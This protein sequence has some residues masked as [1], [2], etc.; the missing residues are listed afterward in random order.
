VSDY[1]LRLGANRSARSVLSRLRLPIPL[2][3]RLT[4]SDDPACADRAARVD[5]PGGQLHDH[6]ALTVARAGMRVFVRGSDN[7]VAPY[8]SGAA[9]Y[10]L[11]ATRL[12]SEATAHDGVQALIFD[13]SGLR[14][15]DDLHALYD[16]L[17]PTVRQ[18]K[19]CGR[20]I[21]FG[22]PLDEA[23]TAQ[24]AATQAAL[25]G[26]VRS[27]GKELGRRGTTANLI[28]VAT[29]AEP[30]LEPALRWLL[31]PRSAF[32]SGQTLDITGAAVGSV[33]ASSPRPLA[34]RR[35]LVTGAARGIGE[36]TATALA[37]AGAHVLCLDRP[38]TDG[39]LARLAER[40]GGTAVAL[41]ITDS[42]APEQLVEYVQG[43]LHG[44]VHNAGI[45]RDR[46]LA[47][48]SRDS[49]SATLSVN[50]LAITLLHD[51][52]D[53][54]LVD[55]ARV[56]MLSS[57]AGIAGNVGQS[58][59]AASK[60]GVIGLVKHLAPRLAARGITVNAVAPGFIETQ[61]TAAIPMATREAGRRLSS[62]AQGGLPI[63]VAELVTFL[64]EPGSIGL[65]GTTVRVCGQ[66][67][68]GA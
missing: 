51:A 42:T 38:D 61:M 22:R 25:D 36:A 35:I 19:R 44:V 68:I 9:A 2:P 46:T 54:H 37:A 12:Q 16:A 57:I 60:A 11:S 17:N 39:T 45:T 18:L 33:P 8:L 66:S 24:S 4:R 7:E 53:P 49:W 31:S 32:I 59:Y 21:V 15:V 64:Q 23:T 14:S 62:L 27:M 10:S 47:K 52:L 13:A 40:L 67:F 26:F 29:G 20:L 55:G 56:V 58:N 50:L 6:I 65:T 34:Q 43:G 41:D 30:R 3:Q 1:L 5:G 48:M 63:D 28:R